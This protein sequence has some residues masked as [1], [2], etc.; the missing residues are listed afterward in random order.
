[1]ETR[2]IIAMVARQ[3]ELLVAITS[4]LGDRLPQWKARTIRLLSG[5]IDDQ[6]LR[7]LN[8]LSAGSW[9][10]EKVLYQDFMK[11]LLHGLNEFP[12]AYLPKNPAAEAPPKAT[13]GH[14][15][16][17]KKV[18][19]VHGHD[20]TAKIDVARTL[21]RLGLEPIVLHE[22]PSKGK[23]I[24]EKFEEHASL[25]SY[26]IV[27]LTPDDIGYPKDKD[28][29]KKPRARQ[30]V[31]LE[32]GYFAGS[33]GRERVCVLF[34]GSTEVPSD[35]IGVVYVPIDDSGAWRFQIA[36]EMRTAGLP[37]DLNKLA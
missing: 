35:Y 17:S 5:N 24:I 22:Q 19:V 14:Q 16:P 12:S 18:F 26:A 6:E 37:I 31:I 11:G 8:G 4:D 25:A 30:N 32:L 13:K 21:E 23:T 36:K 33:L 9:P 3:L 29:E 2:E 34:K 1:M 10:S 20:E 7:I 28:A 27:L 15:M